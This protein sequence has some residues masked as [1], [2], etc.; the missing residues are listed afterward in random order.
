MSWLG[1]AVAWSALIACVLSVLSELR[2]R[3]LRAEARH[4]EHELELRQHEAEIAAAYDRGRASRA[5]DLELCRKDRDYWRDMLVRRLEE[6]K[7]GGN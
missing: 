2:G 3:R 1:T 7:P 5:E 4:R 6:R